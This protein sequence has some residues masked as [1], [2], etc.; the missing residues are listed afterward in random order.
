L[1]RDTIANTG[2]HGALTPDI[3][4]V[5]WL[6]KKTI[7]KVPVIRIITGYRAGMEKNMGKE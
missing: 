5:P 7:N 3:C 1:V 2:L 4:N 6:Q